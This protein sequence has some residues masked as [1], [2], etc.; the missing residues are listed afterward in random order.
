MSEG[1]LES[2]A[3]SGRLFLLLQNV[4]V[5]E[6]VL[7]FVGLDLGIGFWKGAIP[8]LSVP[9]FNLPHDGY[10]GLGIAAF[11]FVVD[12]GEVFAYDVASVGAGGGG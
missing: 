5:V 6:V 12:H 2:F 3:F 8:L 11:G 9:Q 10:F 1:A 4:G 7:V